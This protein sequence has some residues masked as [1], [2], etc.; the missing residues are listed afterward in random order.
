MAK[1]TFGRWFFAKHSVF[2][3]RP[4]LDINELC[5]WNIWWLWFEIAY[6]REGM[7]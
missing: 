7:V 3:L 2:T 1:P 5:H 4:R 6:C